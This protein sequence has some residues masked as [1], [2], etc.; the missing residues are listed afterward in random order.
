[1]LFRRPKEIVTTHAGLR[2]QRATSAKQTSGVSATWMPAWTEP[3]DGRTFFVQILIR[4]L[5]IEI[6]DRML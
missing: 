4:G 3:L 2:P 5:Q 6:G 1:M